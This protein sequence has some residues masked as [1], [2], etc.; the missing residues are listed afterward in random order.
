[1]YWA[2]RL[3]LTVP[4]HIGWLHTIT[5]DSSS[6]LWQT[7]FVPSLGVASLWARNHTESRGN[8][9]RDSLWWLS[10]QEKTQKTKPNKTV[11]GLRYS[12]IVWNS[13][14]GLAA[15]VQDVVTYNSVF[16]GFGNKKVKHS[17]L[18]DGGTFCITMYR[19]QDCAWTYFPHLL[20]A[21]LIGKVLGDKERKLGIN[22][23]D[24]RVYSHVSSSVRL[25]LTA[26]LNADISMLTCWPWQC[27]HLGM[28]PCCL[29]KGQG[30]TKILRIYH[31]GPWMSV[32]KTLHQ[33]IKHM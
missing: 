3:C 1:M 16:Y 6:S 4:V 21:F 23:Q 31:Q 12:I 19:K 30:I 22:E 11:M 7:A 25:Y 15:S 8:A 13:L 10:C 27:W 28:S 9:A 20:C 14:S 32:H 29:E 24:K 2:A 18:H 26:A 17:V 33:S 5:T